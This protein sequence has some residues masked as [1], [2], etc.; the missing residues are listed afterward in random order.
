MAEPVVKCGST[1]TVSD[2]FSEASKPCSR[3]G[4]IT[5]RL[6]PASTVTR[7]NCCARRFDGLHCGGGVAPFGTA[8]Q[9]GSG[10]LAGVETCST[11]TT[12]PGSHNG[13]SAA[14]NKVATKKRIRSGRKPSV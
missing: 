12:L 6:F 9:L 1:Y 7:Q 5:K 4:R 8:R 14:T 11:A 2:G 10:S 3:Y 13:V